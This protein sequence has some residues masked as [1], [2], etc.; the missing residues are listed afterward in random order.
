[1]SLD[2]LQDCSCDARGWVRRSVFVFFSYAFMAATKVVRKLDEGVD[3][4]GDWDM[5][6]SQS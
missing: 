2:E 1:M 5:V 6:R 4:D 3:V